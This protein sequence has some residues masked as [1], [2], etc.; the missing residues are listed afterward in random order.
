MRAYRVCYE[1]N[2]VLEGSV[3]CIWFRR[4]LVELVQSELDGDVVHDDFTQCNGLY[5]IFT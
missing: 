5:I 3:Y 1:Y 4:I 2:K